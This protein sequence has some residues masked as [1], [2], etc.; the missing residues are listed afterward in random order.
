M[1]RSQGESW[2]RPQMK[3]HEKYSTHF[4]VKLHVLVLLSASLWYYSCIVCTVWCCS[5]MLK[6]ITHTFITLLSACLIC[7]CAPPQ[8]MPDMIMSINTN[9]TP[10]ALTGIVLISNRC[11]FS[12]CE[13]MKTL[14][15]IWEMSLKMNEIQY[16]KSLFCCHPQVSV[17]IGASPPTACLSKWRSSNRLQI[18]K[19]PATC[20]YVC[21][22]LSACLLWV[23]HHLSL[24]Q[25]HEVSLTACIIIFSAS[26]TKWDTNGWTV[27][28]STLVSIGGRLSETHSEKLL[29]IYYVWI[30]IY[31]S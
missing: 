10:P 4:Y 12:F 13:D 5:N 15:F 25:W 20:S 24:L 31:W 23:N 2:L 28:F 14:T 27:Q 3:L 19:W 29:G 26:Q 8:P 6:R 7:D 1:L 22:W 16:F 9:N 18:D 21:F 30:I 11:T 17:K